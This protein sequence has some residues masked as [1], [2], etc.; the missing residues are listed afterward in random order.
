MTIIFI[1]LIFNILILYYYKNI[2][3]FVNVFDFPDNKLKLHKNKTPILGGIIVIL[4]YLVF[5][6]TY[7]F[8]EKNYYYTFELKEILSLIF[9]LISFFFVGFYDDKK[10]L[11]PFKKIILL[12]LILIIA[13]TVNTNLI[14][15]KISLS[16]FENKIFF[17]KFSIPFTIF[18]II[19]LTN[20]LNF[21]DGIN[22]QSSFF[23][24]II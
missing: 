15:E 4:N 12:I 5:F 11:S 2:T 7:Y 17:G 16:F 22:G 3:E 6:S 8:Y 23:F 18:C 21:F 1:L 19:L 9:L 13:L 20:S 24:I 14:I 10:K